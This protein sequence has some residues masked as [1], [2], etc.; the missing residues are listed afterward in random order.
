MPK[1]SGEIEITIM[2][3]LFAKRDVEVDAGHGVSGKF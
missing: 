1:R 2:A 3:G